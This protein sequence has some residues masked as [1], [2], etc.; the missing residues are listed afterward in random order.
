MS[1]LSPEQKELYTK[2]RDAYASLDMV[3]LPLEEFRELLNEADPSGRGRY[4]RWMAER[5]ASG[6]ALEE[7]SR[8]QLTQGKISQLHRILSLF[9]AI[10]ST[11]PEDQRNILDYRSLREVRQV[12]E[13][14][15]TKRTTLNHTLYE[16]LTFTQ[17][18]DSTLVLSAGDI[19]VHKPLCIEEAAALFGD[20]ALLCDAGD[21]L[22]GSLLAEG[23][24]T[25][26]ISKGNIL[27]CAKP[28]EEDAY[29]RVFDSFGEHALFEDMLL[30]EGISGR[31]VWDDYAQVLREMIVIDP[32][33][34]FDM[35]MDEPEPYQVALMQ[36]PLVLH[37]DREIPEDL[38][39][40]VLSDARVR[41]RVEEAG[42][43]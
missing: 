42:P 40:A 43:F 34:P 29:G 31:P 12:V 38:L 37:Q 35:E 2:A 1:Q 20:E 3:A 11:L 28:M 26:F 21:G 6:E 32:T 15:G 24:I 18:H 25:I 4:T 14:V 39:E 23:E 41:V 10:K 36:F 5:L 22:Y 33:L 17:V 16:T 9:D 13:A 27:L 19:S 8:W 30:E 7:W